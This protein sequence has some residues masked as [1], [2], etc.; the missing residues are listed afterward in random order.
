MAAH[1]TVLR[2]MIKETRRHVGS[3]LSKMPSQ[4]NTVPLAAV[5]R[6]RVKG[7]RPAYPF[8]TVDLT[9]S[10]DITPWLKDTYFDETLDAQVYINEQRI[11][12]TITCYGKDC[13]N[14][15]NELK[16]RM[17]YDVD[18]WQLNTETGAVFQYFSGIR[19]LPAFLSTDFIESAEM[20]VTFVAETIWYPTYEDAKDIQ[21]VQATGE[22]YDTLDKSDDP[23]QVD[24]DEP[25]TLTS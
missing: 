23:Y 19:D 13:I 18:R 25:N 17:E 11:P 9:A 6:D 10:Q 12:L 16:I 14:I 15:L 2:G 21:R 24:I 4:P 8:I 5:I 3:Q 22:F 20:D 7:V 1:D